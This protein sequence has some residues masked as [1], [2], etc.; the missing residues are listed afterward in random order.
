[1][2]VIPE[3]RSRPGTLRKYLFVQFLLKS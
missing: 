3:E 1:M 2:P